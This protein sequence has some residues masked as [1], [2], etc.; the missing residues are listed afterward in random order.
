MKY[1][2]IVA[3]CDGVNMG[4]GLNNKI[5]WYLPTDLASFKKLTVGQGHNVVV[6][7]RKTYDSLPVSV[8]PLPKRKNIVL[9]RQPPPHDLPPGVIWCQHHEQLITTLQQ[10]ESDGT[11]DNTTAFL[12]EEPK[13]TNWHYNTLK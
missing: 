4:I 2:L 11:D 13:F 5:P 3:T 12:S 9:S 10:I 7:G 8:R 1:N 6:M